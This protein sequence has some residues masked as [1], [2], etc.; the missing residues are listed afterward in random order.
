MAR[1]LVLTAAPGRG[2]SEAEIAEARDAVP[3]AGAPRRLAAEAAEIPAPAAVPVA[4][5]G[6]DANWVPAAGRKKRLLLAD[7]D[8]TIIGCECIDEVAALAGVGAEVA[9]ITERAMAG[10]LDFE[11]ALAERVALLEGLPVAALDEVLES[12]IRLNPGAA[13]LVRTMRALGAATALV[14]GGFTHFTGPVA[15]R[16]GFAEHRANR[17]ETR[18]GRLTGHVVPPV[19]GR[20]AKLAALVEI[21]G[22]IGATPAEAIALGDGANDAAMIEA[23]GLGIG[24]RPKP[25]LAAVSDA[26]LRHSDLSA[27]LHL[28]GIPESAFL[29]G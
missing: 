7:M 15:A 5:E 29:R 17:L 4:L 24:Y 12:R 21:A 13:T 2:L 9:R 25:A 27:A 16:A 3:G 22:R 28:Q 8:S 11:G 1:V 10:E 18:A 20:E 14:S 6:V 23:A 19:L 26:A